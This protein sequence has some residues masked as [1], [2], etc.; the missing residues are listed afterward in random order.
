MNSHQRRILIFAKAPEPG[1]VKTRLQTHLDPV[2]CANIHKILT[3]NTLSVACQSHLALVELWVTPSF[4]HP[5]F[6]NCE[7][8]F[9]IKFNIQRGISL[10]ERMHLALK[11]SLVECKTAVIIGTD[12]PTITKA[13]LK[14]A[15]DML[16]TDKDIVLGPANDGGYVLIG[17]RRTH[18]ALFSNIA[19]GSSRVLAQTQTA[20]DYL[21]WSWAKLDS[22]QDIDRPQDLSSLKIN[23]HDL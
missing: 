16:E 11:Q 20:L 2:A 1:L 23:S 5:F 7:R 4:D 13:Y 18:S 3:T 22:L 19:W 9:P 6:E 15:F 14:K 8:L 12:C 17:A 21:G 10:G